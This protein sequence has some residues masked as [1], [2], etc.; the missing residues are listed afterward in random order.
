MNSQNYDNIES[1]VLKKQEKKAKLRKKTMK[2]SGS[3][4]KKLQE[5]I[6]KGIKN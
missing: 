2:V 5:I 1:E 4:V 6:K 3:G